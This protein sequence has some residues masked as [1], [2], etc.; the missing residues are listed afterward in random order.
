MAQGGGIVGWVARLHPLLAL[1]VIIGGLVL[2]R[3]AGIAAAMLFQPDAFAP[4]SVLSVIVGAAVMAVFFIG[5]PVAIAIHVLRTHGPVTQVRPA[6]I[7]VSLLVILPAFLTAMAF[8]ASPGPQGTGFA[9]AVNIPIFAWLAG[10]FYILW[11]A[12][13]GLVQAEDGRAVAFNRV[14]GTFFMFYFLP[15][16]IYFLQRRVRRLTAGGMPPQGA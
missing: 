15:L 8:F 5:Y 1:M 10:V 6:R 13:R 9:I 14:I 12:A 3:I 11:T 16:G 2:G 4:I 7:A